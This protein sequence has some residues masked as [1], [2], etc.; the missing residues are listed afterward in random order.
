MNEAIKI[1]SIHIYHPENIRNNQYYFDKYPNVKNLP[2]LLND[3]G[4]RQRYITS[5]PDENVLTMS[6]N[7]LAPM[8]DKDID[9]L[10]FAST[11]MEYLSP[12][13]ALYL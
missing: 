9:I 5:Q 8:S 1:S 10:I 2:E 11:T 12:L 4:Q 7:A 3:F 6:I 13:N